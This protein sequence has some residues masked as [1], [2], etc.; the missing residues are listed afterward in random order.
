MDWLIHNPIADIHGPPFLLVYGVIA[1][2]VIVVAYVSAK[3]RDRTG[4]HEPPPVPGA[5]DPYEVAYLRGGK[6]AVIRTALYALHQRG[7]MELLPKSWFKPARIVAKAD[8]GAAVALTRLEERVFRSLVSPVEPSSPF[9]NVALAVDVERLCEPLRNKLESEELLRPAAARKSAMRPPLVAS[10]VLV[11]LTLYKI[12]MAEG[13]PFGF[14][15]ILTVVALVLLWILVAPGARA[16]IS[17]RG[18]AYLKRLQL[19]YGNMVRPAAT[20]TGESSQPDMASV[21]LVGL[22]GLGIL[23]GTPDAAFADLFARSAAAGGGCG[24]GCGGGGGGGCGGGGC[25]G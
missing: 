17:D 5:F 24:S 13:R 7:L 8:P 6:N 9:Q 1:L 14:L 19:A 12:A 15:I 21:A 3:P 10:A 22:F 20:R 18:T 11:S 2:V 25:G 4:L 23:S 16:R